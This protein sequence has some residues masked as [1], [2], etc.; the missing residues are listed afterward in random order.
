ML[1]TAL[2]ANRRSSTASSLS[3]QGLP[4][5]HGRIDVESCSQVGRLP[6]A[7]KSLGEVQRVFTDPSRLGLTMRETTALM[8]VHTL[9]RA[10]TR[11]SGY[12]G[13]WDRNA[14]TANVMDNNFFTSMIEVGWDRR[15]NDATHHQWTR[16]NA[17][18]S[19][20]LNTDMA[21]AFE[22]GSDD[23][24]NSRQ[25]QTRP[26]AEQGRGGGRGGGRGCGTGRGQ[27]C[28]TSSNYGNVESF[29]NDE[30]TFLT[31]FVAVW[32][33]TTELGHAALCPL[34]RCVDGAGGCEACEAGVA[35]AAAD[36]AEADA[37]VEAA[38]RRYQQAVAAAGT[39][40]GAGA[41]GEISRAAV[42]ASAGALLL[43]AAG[44][45]VWAVRR[46]RRC[47]VEL[48]EGDRARAMIFQKRPSLLAHAHADGSTASFVER[49]VAVSVAPASMA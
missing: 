13:F 40:P 34:D 36:A 49:P 29:A 41:D 35:R 31:E 24:V 18:S 48:N 16:G 33:K 1:E 45:G 11:N 39:G 37:A 46:W 17:P 43:L 23:D 38:E 26:V 4:F 9:G 7:D 3:R 15:R 30:S 5:R 21:L 19:L 22:I 6:H 47:N 44:G 25:C 32:T 8:G 2:R 14:R 20:M 42:T 10:E 28:C 27:N 12:D